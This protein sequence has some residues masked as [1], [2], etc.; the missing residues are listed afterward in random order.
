MLE[1]LATRIVLFSWAPVGS[2]KVPPEAPQVFV[3][4]GVV[5]SGCVAN[6]F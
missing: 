5:T 2:E 6:T 1:L 4:P 3:L